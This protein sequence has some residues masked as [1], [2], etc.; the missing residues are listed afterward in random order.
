MEK[1]HATS[2]MAGDDFS[3]AYFCA[4]FDSCHNAY[5]VRKLNTI[6]NVNT[7]NPRCGARNYRYYMFSRRTVSPITLTYHRGV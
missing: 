1:T 2:Y 7:S 5:A 6:S 4:S 3:S